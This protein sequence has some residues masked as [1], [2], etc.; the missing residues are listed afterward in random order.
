MGMKRHV[1]TAALLSLTLTAG[2]AA[3]AVLFHDGDRHDHAPAVDAAD[4]G[5][6]AAAADGPVDTPQV[7]G[8][9]DGQRHPR[10]QFHPNERRNETDDV[11]LPG[12]AL[13]PDGPLPRHLTAAGAWLTGRSAH[14]I[15]ADAVKIADREGTTARE[16]FHMMM[17][18]AGFSRFD[19]RHAV[20]HIRHDGG[21]Y[22]IPMPS[23][24]QGAAPVDPIVDPTPDGHDKGVPAEH[25]DR[26]R[27]AIADGRLTEAKFGDLAEHLGLTVR[28]VQVDGEHLAAT[29]DF[30]PRRVNVAV[31][32]GIVVAI[33]HFG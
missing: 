21:R 13:R 27:A 10:G 15:T 26:L 9:D 33:V 32:D 3:G 22:P 8:R 29:K 30:S 19:V 25:A 31:A 16:A 20:A 28:V 23:D 24:G 4:S 14:D 7:D 6:A 1:Q 2:I 12:D 17:R 18:R 5:T 11:L